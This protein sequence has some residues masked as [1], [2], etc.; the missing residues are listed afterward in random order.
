GEIRDRETA[1]IAV[2][3]SITGHLVLSTLHTNSAPA[4]VTRLSQMG[5][6]PYLIADSVKL[7]IAQR[8]VRVLCAQCRAKEPVPEI[9]RAMLDKTELEVFAKAFQPRGCA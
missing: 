9:E 7:I 3:A 1:E 8:L 6:A 2:K 4:T 5:V